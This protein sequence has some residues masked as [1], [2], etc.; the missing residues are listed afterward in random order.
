MVI[1]SNAS[2]IRVAISRNVFVSSILLRVGISGAA[3]AVWAAVSAVSGETSFPTALTALVAG[4][5]IAGLSLRK[6]R[7]LLERDG[8]Q[9]ARSLSQG[10]RN[11]RRVASV[12]AA[13][14]RQ[15]QA[16]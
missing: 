4:V 8:D 3:L 14:T 16:I 12:V 1:G 10:L 9:D 7:S 6:A 15:R 11:R 13:A 2:N 5:A